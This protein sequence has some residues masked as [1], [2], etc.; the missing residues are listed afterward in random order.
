LSEE[1][2]WERLSGEGRVETFVWYLRHVEPVPSEIRR[3]TPYNVAVIRLV[4]GPRVMS[5]VENVEFGSLAVGDAVTAAFKDTS[6][7]WA[8]LR[9]VPA[10]AAS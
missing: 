2:R 3:N 9:F 4:E 7:G 8:S 6:D 1:F 5:N 10:D